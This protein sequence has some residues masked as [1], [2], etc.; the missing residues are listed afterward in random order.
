MNSKLPSQPNNSPNLTFGFIKIAQLI[1]NDFA[2]H[3]QE[4]IRF[5][6]QVQDGKL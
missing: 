5:I 1:Y 4:K 6:N 3:H 2:F